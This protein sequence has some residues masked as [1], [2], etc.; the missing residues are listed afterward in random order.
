MQED[1]CIFLCAFFMHCV[2]DASGISDVWEA[3]FLLGAE[4][5]YLRGLNRLLHHLHRKVFYSGNLDVVILIA[6]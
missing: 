5:L 1:F 2:E 4:K 3:V 6:T